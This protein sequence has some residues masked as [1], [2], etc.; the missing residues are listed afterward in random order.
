MAVD[1]SQLLS[2]PAEEI[3]APKALPEGSFLGLITAFKFDIAKTPNDKEQPEKPVCDLTV[4]LQEAMEDVDAAD[5]NEA[6]DGQPLSAKPAMKH[7]LWLTPD[8]QYRVVELCENLGIPKEGQTLASMIPE[9][10]NKTVLVNL[11]KV[12][13][14]KAGQSDVFFTNIGTIAPAP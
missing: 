5:L 1:F 3:K 6:L 13:S 11:V 12:Q 8:A 10:V 14:K 2:K 4:K 9:L 7:T